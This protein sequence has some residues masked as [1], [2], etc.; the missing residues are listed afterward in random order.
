M[1]DCHCCFLIKATTSTRNSSVFHG[2]P[3]RHS[4]TSAPATSATNHRLQASSALPRRAPDR[5]DV[6]LRFRLRSAVAG[7][8][9]VAVAAELAVAR[10]AEPLEVMKH[11][12]PSTFDGHT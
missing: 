4:P 12:P 5:Y 2:L 6:I 9:V 1:W 3:L 7:A 11:H 10:L 8:A